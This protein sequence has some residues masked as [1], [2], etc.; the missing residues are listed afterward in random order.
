MV[1]LVY[2][3]K[4]LVF[5]KGKFCLSLHYNADYIYLFINR[6]KIYKIKASNKNNNLPP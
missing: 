4:L 6:K 3:K 1:A 2:Q 5:S